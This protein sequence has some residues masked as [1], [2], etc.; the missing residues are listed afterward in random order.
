MM[1][2]KTQNRAGLEKGEIDEGQDS[3]GVQCMHGAD[4]FEIVMSRSI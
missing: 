3:E 1:T 4:C 2:A